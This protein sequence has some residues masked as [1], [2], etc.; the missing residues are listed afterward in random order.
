MSVETLEYAASMLVSI[1]L[2]QAVESEKKSL[3][4]CLTFFGFDKV[5]QVFTS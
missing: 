1:L 2:Q 5:K 3:Q 4:G